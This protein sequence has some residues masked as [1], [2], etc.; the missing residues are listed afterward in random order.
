MPSNDSL[1]DKI[2]RN[3]FRFGMIAGFLGVPFLWMAGDSLV[4][5]IIGQRALPVESFW[6]YETS[7]ALIGAFL[8]G[9]GASV[10]AKWRK[11]EFVEARGIA[12]TS[13]LL[14]VALYVGQA[15]LF[16][17]TS[18]FFLSALGS[19][20]LTL[21]IQRHLPFLLCLLLLLGGLFGPRSNQGVES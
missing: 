13:G 19:K 5:I 6:S 8:G 4:R 11:G 16:A 17:G 21:I 3:P 1:S 12:F 10:W 15:A 14:G 7:G 20:L 9:Q 2:A 18:P